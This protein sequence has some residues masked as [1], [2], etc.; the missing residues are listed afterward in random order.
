M[1]FGAS[2]DDAEQHATE[3]AQARGA[4][5][6]SPY[7]DPDVILGQASAGVEILAGFDGPV[8]V[9]CPV[10]GGGLA[11]GIGL[12]L[13]ARPGSILIGV[14]AARSCAMAEAIKH[15]KVT[16]I[17]AQ[18]TL[19][20]GLAGNLEDGTVTVALLAQYAE[21]MV[22]VTEAQIQQAMRHLATAHGIIAEGAGAVAV[23]AILAEKIPQARRQ[24]V[25]A[26]VS[27][28]N[29]DLGTWTAAVQSA[30]TDA[31]A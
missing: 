8:T 2:Y 25:V 11:A 9:V 5:Y 14:E 1:I 21:A 26:L 3:L 15:G 28:R 31:T 27:G 12:A 22:T 18:P 7:N 20:E 24:P 6:L 19:A 16:P 4:R 17:D 30:V 10:G 23:A 29:I 13:A